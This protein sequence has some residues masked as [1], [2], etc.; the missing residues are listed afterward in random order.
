MRSV[1]ATMRTSEELAK[2]QTLLAAVPSCVTPVDQPDQKAAQQEL[3]R[4]LERPVT[5]QA[6]P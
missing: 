5:A 3:A 4:A 1:G 2:A 6:Q